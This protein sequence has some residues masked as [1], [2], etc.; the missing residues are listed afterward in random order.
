MTQEIFEKATG[1]KCKIDGV[2]KLKETVKNPKSSMMDVANA[3]ARYFQANPKELIEFIDNKIENLQKEFDTLCEC[4]HCKYFKPKPEEKPEGNGN[5]G[6]NKQ[7]EG[8][9]NGESDNG[10][11]NP[12]EENSEDKEDEG[13]GGTGEEEAEGSGDEPQEV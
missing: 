11:K 4:E 1:I 13:G 10:D 3:L 9:E 12:D 6:E 8:G 5:G 2:K 7:P